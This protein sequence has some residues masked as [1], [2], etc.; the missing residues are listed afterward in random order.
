MTSASG[1]VVYATDGKDIEVGAVKRPVELS[2]PK[3]P[4]GSG[5]Q[6]PS[7]SSGAQ[8]VQAENRTVYWTPNGK[9]YHF[10]KDCITLRHSKTIKSGSLSE[11]MAAG[12]TDPCDVCAGG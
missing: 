3:A 7:P 2:G 12:K 8:A 4:A 9:S 1:T 6:E 5:I 11:A 10:D